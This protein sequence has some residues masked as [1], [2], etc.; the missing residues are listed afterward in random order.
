MPMCL[1]SVVCMNKG[2]VTQALLSMCGASALV[3]ALL[4][5]V[6]FISTVSSNSVIQAKTEQEVFTI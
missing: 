2:S 1:C 6:I 4:Y 5:L 3:Q